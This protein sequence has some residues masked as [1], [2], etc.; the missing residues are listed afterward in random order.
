ME[1]KSLQDKSDLPQRLNQIPVSPNLHLVPIRHHSP[2]CAHHLQALIQRDRPESILI[3]GP[4]DATPLLSYLGEQDAEPPLSFYCYYRAHKNDNNQSAAPRFRC[5]YPLA[6]FSPEWVAIREGLKLGAEVKFIDL[7]YDER[8]LSGDDSDDDDN[9]EEVSLLGER[10]WLKADPMARL[11]ELS[12]CRDFNEWWDRYFESGAIT[13]ESE[14]YFRNILSWCLLLRDSQHI[15]NIEDSSENRARER[16]MA[17]NIQAELETGRRCLVVTGGY[18]TEAIAAY[19]RESIAEPD[20][21]KANGER[22]VYLL[23]YT[24]QR[25]D[26][27]NHYAAGIPD[28][29]YYQEV[30]REMQRDNPQPYA[31]A[32]KTIVLRVGHALADAGEPVSLP[33]SI[34]AAALGQR[35]ASLRATPFGRPEL[36][37]SMITAF[38]KD[39][40]E[41]EESERLSFI[42]RQL[43][44]DQL[45]R[46]P[47]AYPIVPIV[48]DFR[49]QCQRFKLPLT[50]LKEQEK[51]LDIYR[52]ERHRQISRL[53]HQL[54]F[55]DIPY[56][57]WQAG[58]DF[59]TGT[60]LARVREIWS[61]RWLPETEAT[62]TECMMYGARLEEASLQ[63]LLAQLEHSVRQPAAPTLL[64]EALRMGLQ[65]VTGRILP[66]I[67]R[68]LT[69]ENVFPALVQGLV[70][71][72]L[73]YSAQTAL[74]SVRLAGLQPLLNAAFERTCLR[75]TWLGQMDEEATETCLSALADLNSLARMEADWNPDIALFERCVE[76][77][78][79]GSAPP[80]L[81]GQAAAILTV[82]QIW[83][84]D[85]KYYRHSLQRLIRRGLNLT[86]LGDFLL[87]FL[88][89]AR[90]LI[91]Q[92]PELV[93][94]MGEVML[95]WDE[96]T[97]LDALPNLRLAFTALKPRETSQN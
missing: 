6:A 54:R 76:A 51:N 71:L 97:F 16:Y 72:N 22:G 78:Y 69:E 85:T 37:D 41:T 89:L 29:G 80:A 32:G 83:S 87:G 43:V 26:A 47:K 28:T 17:A 35:L 70:Q 59:T 5:F 18:H 13:L 90:S 61:L 57:E 75:L 58:P 81:C 48:A 20:T 96:A 56:G 23:P 14:D 36:L 8:I 40:L 65:S 39:A 92:T 30:W 24:L 21:I 52:S 53:L 9:A 34:E 10:D 3:E 27:A 68:W 1:P 25:L 60:E 63:C 45:G 95:D 64:I 31:E 86:Y 55:L 12:A 2:A 93:D 79:Q 73:A 66:Y 7:P 77:L 49:E 82:R 84:S 67:E 44:K 4:A 15:N 38:G 19:L 62:L 91:L 11:I 94:A 46:L 33:D 74:A 42:S 88:P 50:P